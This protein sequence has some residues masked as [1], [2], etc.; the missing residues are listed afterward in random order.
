MMAKVVVVTGMGVVSA[1]APSLGKT[2][3]RLLCGE[4]GIQKCHPFPDIPAQPLA[5]VESRPSYLEE[6]L[7]PA[8]SEA[9]DDAG[10]APPMRDCGVAIGSS[11]GFQSQ[12][13]EGASAYHTLIPSP[14]KKRPLLTTPEHLAHIY[15]VSPAS[16]V[17]QSVAAQ[18]PVLAPR[19]ACATGI[20][21]IA[22]GADLIRA[23]YCSRVI[24][25]AVEAPITPLTLAG[26][27]KMGAMA[28]SGAYPFDQNREG[29]VLGEGAAILV[30]EEE[31]SAQ[32]RQAR[33]YGQ[34]LGVG[35]TVDA[36]HMT[37][38]ETSRQAA[39]TAIQD[40]LQ[41][42]GLK[43]SDIGYIHA[44]GTATHLNDQ[45]EAAVIKALFPSSVAVSSTKG[46]TGHT[47]GASAAFG[48]IFSLMALSHKV[49]PPCV[50]LRDPAFDLNFVR[51]PL[52]HNMQSALCLSSGFGG[53]NTVLALSS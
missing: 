42:S 1:L 12:W 45:A 18:G 25:G 40:C 3:H 16:I 5:L 39:I 34:I 2:W 30:L 32:K 7:K 21:A 51:E 6:L 13:E 19:A 4:S 9:L 15:G 28:Q 53:Q 8:L 38:P 36:Y 46:A 31:S 35:L 23:G 26:F 17:A 27:N 22:Q 33:I 37:A 14:T 43:T 11:R 24:V 52:R 29:F 50:G 41:R 47:L 44:H 10:L 20:W 48:C 49:L